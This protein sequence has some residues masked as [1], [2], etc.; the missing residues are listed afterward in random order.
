MKQWVFDRL[1]G[2]ELDF[3]HD[4]ILFHKLTKG[5]GMSAGHQFYESGVKRKYWTRGTKN[6]YIAVFRSRAT[7]S[8]FYEIQNSRSTILKLFIKEKDY[9]NIV[10]G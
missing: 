2:D 5:R 10:K 1:E 4:I 9:K 7:N 6:I 8:L 3:A